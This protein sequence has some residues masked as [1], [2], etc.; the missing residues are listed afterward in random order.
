M[1]SKSPRHRRPDAERAAA[2]KLLISLDLAVDSFA[3]AAASDDVSLTV[4]YFAVTER[5]KALIAQRPRKL[6]ETLAEEIAATC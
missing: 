4:D 6:L 5:V 3:R 1:T 2:Q